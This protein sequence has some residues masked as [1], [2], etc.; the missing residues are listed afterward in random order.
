MNTLTQRWGRATRVALLLTLAMTLAGCVDLSGQEEA[1]PSEFTFPTPTAEMPNLTS[2][3]P[4]A[5]MSDSP[6][7]VPSPGYIEIPSVEPIPITPTPTI[8]PVELPIDLSKP[9]LID[10]SGL[11]PPGAYLQGAWFSP[12][13]AFIYYTVYHSGSGRE[14][15]RMDATLQN[16]NRLHELETIVDR[17]GANLGSLSPDGEK[18]FYLLTDAQPFGLWVTNIDGSDEQH[19]KIEGWPSGWSPDGEAFF[20]VVYDTTS[21]T[22]TF[23]KLDLNSGQSGKF[24]TVPE[25]DGGLIWSPDGQQV[26]IMA[27]GEGWVNLYVTNADGTGLRRLLFP[28]TRLEQGVADVIWSPDGT[29][30]AMTLVSSYD[31]SIGKIRKAWVMDIATGKLQQLT[32]TRTV[33]LYWNAKNQRVYYVTGEKN[34]LFIWSINPAGSDQRL[35]A[36]F[37]GVYVNEYLTSALGTFV[38]WSNDGKRLILWEQSSENKFKLAVLP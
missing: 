18:I 20:Y 23:W 2:L 22:A 9:T 29:M 8:P 32:N 1:G 13:S 27:G 4:T 34:T 16:R 17:E 35:E 5:S 12:D 7:P 14:Y 37:P 3:T 25:Q 38:Y 6:L 36:E 11:T 15:W 24:V 30:L 19:L 28:E 31:E 26:A 21:Q 10:L 33:A